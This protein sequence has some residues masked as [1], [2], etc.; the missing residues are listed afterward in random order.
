MTKYDDSEPD[1]LSDLSPHLPDAYQLA[2]EE[3]KEKGCYL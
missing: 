3:E 1:D 2:Q